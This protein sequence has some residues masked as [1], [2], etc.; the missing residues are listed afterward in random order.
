MLERIFGL[1]ASNEWIALGFGLGTGISA[2]AASRYGVK[3][4]DPAKENI[5]ETIALKQLIDIREDLNN[6][7]STMDSYSDNLLT[8]LNDIDRGLTHQMHEIDVTLSVIK[9]RLP[10]G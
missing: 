1:I 3:I 10:R 6:V 7:V 2:I 8:R 9:D 5:T 4:N